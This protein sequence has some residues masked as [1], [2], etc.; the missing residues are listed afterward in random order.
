M[1]VGLFILREVKSF[2]D[3]K[4]INSNFLHLITCS[5][6]FDIPAKTRSRMTTATTFSRQNDTGS[7][8]SNTQYRENLL[9]VVVLY[10]AIQNDT[11]L[12]A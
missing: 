3:S 7:R 8:V 5:R 2:P 10:C 4:M 9:L 12:K 6:H 1:L 11:E